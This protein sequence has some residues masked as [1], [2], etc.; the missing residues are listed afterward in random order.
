MPAQIDTRRAHLT[1][2]HGDIAAVYTWVNDE[3]AMVLVPWRRPGAPWYVV[4]DSAAYTWDDRVQSNV[5]V[6]A[7]KAHQACMVLGI[8]P[9]PTNCRRV[10]GIIIDGLPDLIRMPHAPDKEHYGA[11]FGTLELRADGQPI[12]A[13]EIRLEKEGVAYA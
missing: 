2:H 3:R 8:E 7:R 10:A 9:T 5:P 11:S 12:A 1:R 4:L 13:E 6:V